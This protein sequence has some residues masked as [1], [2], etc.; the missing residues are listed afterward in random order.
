MIIRFGFFY[1]SP[2]EFECLKTNE[3]K[4]NYNLYSVSNK[5]KATNQDPGFTLVEMVIV[6]VILAI[7]SAVAISRLLSGNTFNAVIVRDQIISLSRSAL[8]NSL[9]R[10]NVSLTITPSASG[11]ELTIVTSDVGGTITSVTTPLDT[12]TLSGDINVSSS[13]ET[14]SG[15]DSITNAA[16][17]TVVFGALGDL[18]VSGVSGSTGAISS[19]LR[20][21]IN[22][23]AVNSICFSPSGF[24]YAG[25]CDV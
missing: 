4:E 12:I 9:G 1:V 20:I 2:V 23:I 16:S 3:V 22:D 15:V 8:L 11:D 5:L 21:C 17:M 19:A 7:I 18:G 25:D 10:T 14:I 13:C 24:A 6:I